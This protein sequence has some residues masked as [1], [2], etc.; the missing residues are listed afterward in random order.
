MN[1]EFRVLVLEDNP[2][3]LRLLRE[4]VADEGDMRFHLNAVS[5]LMEALEV[6]DDEPYD[7]IL[8]DLNVPDSN[9][10]DT[11]QS[12]QKSAPDTPV[13]LVTGN[14]DE[15]T[16]LAAV[17]HGAQDYLVKDGLD[18]RALTRAMMYA[19][20]RNRVE[21]ERRQLVAILEATTDVVWTITPDG[22]TRFLNQAGHAVLGLAPDIGLAAVDLME[23][24]APWAMRLV[25]EEAIP[26]AIRDGVWLGETALIGPDRTEIPV[27]QIIIAHRS[28]SGRLLFL[29]SIARDIRERKKTEERLA[30]LAQFDPLTG[31]PNRDLFRDRLTHAMQRARRHERLLALLFIDLDNFKDVNDT[32]GH[33][34]GDQL[35]K[36]VG[37]RL[38]RCLRAEDTVGRLGGDEFTV[39]IENLESIEQLQVVLDKLLREL[40]T[41]VPLAGTEV[42]VT[43]SIGATLYPLGEADTETLL[44]QADAAMYQAK[45]SGRNNYQFYSHELQIRITQRLALAN[46]LRRAVERRE[47]TLEYQPQVDVMTGAVTCLEALVR[48][49]HP[50][51]GLISPRVFIPI[52]EQTG[53]IGALGDWVLRAACRQCALWRAA[54]H[55]HARVSV[56]VSA[57]QF[58]LT[59]MVHI[60]RS[61]LDDAHLDADAL[62]LEITEGL[63][64][65]NLNAV[66]G[67]LRELREMGVTLAVDDF[68]TGYSSLAYLK[69]LPLHCLKIDQSFVR[70][71]PSD[72]DSA[73]IARSILAMAHHLNLSVVAEGVETQEQYDFLVDEGCDAVQGFLF[74]RPLSPLAVEAVLRSGLALR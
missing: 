48:W 64:M 73:A 27:S 53:Q 18:A 65:E 66:E 36:E 9:G 23:H 17:A 44:K 67:V 46:D 34:A 8:A 14:T 41:G 63:M 7:L 55:P 56:N 25:R 19:V 45:S 26:C 59:N 58:R 70:D 60:V 35:L 72:S 32:L 74:A 68:G 38:E 47:L 61:A 12:L 69:H 21:Q 30:R 15:S 3:D 5:R 62:E 31:L 49:N 6:L 52:A 37:K 1:P 33:S 10:L 51:D 2:G 20:E 11:F 57:R 50:R 22:R 40:S 39:L 4:M 28:S 13:I 16:A 42:F 54:G 29:S 71:L 43:A 24:F